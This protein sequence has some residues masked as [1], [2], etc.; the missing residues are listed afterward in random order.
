LAQETISKETER[1]SQ[2]NPTSPA[3]RSTPNPPPAPGSAPHTGN[4]GRNTGRS[5][6]LNNWNVKVM[7]RTSINK[8]TSLEFRTELYDIFNHPQVGQGSGSPFAHLGNPSA[9]DFI[10]SLVNTST[11]I[12]FLVPN[13]SLA[14]AGGRVI[15]YQLKRIF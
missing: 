12:F 3:K 13:T 4:L 8:N 14:D 15:R 2:S 9:S 7:K 6:G 11:A 5:P 10:A 1:E